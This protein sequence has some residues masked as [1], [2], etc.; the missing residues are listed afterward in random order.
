MVAGGWCNH[1]TEGH[2]VDHSNCKKTKAK[3]N[4]QKPKNKTKKTTP[5]WLRPVWPTETTL[6][7]LCFIKMT[8]AHH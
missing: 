7:A 5:D 6:T 8:A 3:Q 2:H 1:I 4:K